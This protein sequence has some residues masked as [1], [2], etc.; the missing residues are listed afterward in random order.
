MDYNE[1]KGKTILLINTVYHHA[2]QRKK[3]GGA[4]RG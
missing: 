1:L 4:I 3:L 2:E